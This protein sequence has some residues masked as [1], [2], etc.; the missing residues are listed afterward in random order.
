MFVVVVNSCFRVVVAVVAVDVAV[1]VAVAVA[2][3]QLTNHNQQGITIAVLN[4]CC[5]WLVIIS[6]LIVCS[7]VN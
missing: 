4:D 7:S 3:V 2:S 1:A 6:L 5:C